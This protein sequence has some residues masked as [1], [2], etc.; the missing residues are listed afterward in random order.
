MLNKYWQDE[1]NNFDDDEIEEQDYNL[2][3]K[4]AIE[5]SRQIK[6]LSEEARSIKKDNDPE[7]ERLTK[8]RD[9]QLNIVDQ[10]Q[11]KLQE[12]L[13]VYYQINKD[14]KDNFDFKNPYVTISQRNQTKWNWD[15]EDKIISSIENNG[16]DKFVKKSIKKGDLKK[17]LKIVGDKVI[18]EDGT[19]IDG[20]EITKEKKTNLK[21]EGE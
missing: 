19:I 7:I 12:K 3:R 17:V 18:T 13:L 8:W 4:Q 9:N 21:V 11:K 10:K 15:N 5:I 16:L 6:A 20:V 2:T 14:Q 1:I